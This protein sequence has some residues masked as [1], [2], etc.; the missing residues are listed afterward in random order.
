MHAGSGETGDMNPVVLYIYI[1]TYILLHVTCK[2]VQLQYLVAFSG[3][4]KAFL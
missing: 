3:H 2:Q 1:Y 4:V